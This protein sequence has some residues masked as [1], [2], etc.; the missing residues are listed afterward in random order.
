VWSISHARLKSKLLF[1]RYSGNKLEVRIR[2]LELLAQEAR[3]LLSLL[4]EEASQLR[5]A[6]ECERMARDAERRV[7]EQ[8]DR[9]GA[10][11]LTGRVNGLREHAARLREEFEPILLR[12]RA[13]W[14]WLAEAIKHELVDACP[15]LARTDRGHW[16]T[17]PEE[18]VYRWLKEVHDAA[19]SRACTLR[20][21]L[22]QRHLE[23]PA[24]GEAGDGLVLDVE[25][26]ELRIGDECFTLSEGK[27]DVLEALITAGKK[28]MHLEE[29]KGVRA[30]AP[31]MLQE[32]RKDIPLSPP[33]IQTPGRSRS[34]PYRARGT[35][36]AS[37]HTG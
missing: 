28:G 11:G 30:S 27:V 12:R 29:L 21:R 13:S 10:M 3:L 32:V 9:P 37:T 19:A 1:P 26:C 2:R 23:S 18:G 22:Q 36:A 20:R 17:V 25:R 24:K 33:F 6:M 4:P 7:A 31:R 16:H 34:G 14:L 8:P 15:R 5:H 35:L